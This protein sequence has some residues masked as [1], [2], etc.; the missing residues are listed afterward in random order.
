[1][2][3]LEKN[4]YVGMQINGHKVYPNLLSGLDIMHPIQVVSADQ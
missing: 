1:M 3:S 2:R 4:L